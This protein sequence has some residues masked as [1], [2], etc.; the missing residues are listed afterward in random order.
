MI[1]IIFFF[2]SYSIIGLLMGT[3]IAMNVIIGDIAPSI[4]FNFSGVPVR[5]FM[6]KEIKLLQ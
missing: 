4:F 6:K 1:K 5:N 3:L 2:F